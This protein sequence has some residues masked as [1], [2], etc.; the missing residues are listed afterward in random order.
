VANALRMKEKSRE[1]NSRS[2]AADT[3]AGCRDTK[4]RRTATAPC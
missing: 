1:D 4:W 3:G 2:H